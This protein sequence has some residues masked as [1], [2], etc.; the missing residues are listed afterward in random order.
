VKLEGPTVRRFCNLALWCLGGVAVLV[1]AAQRHAHL[2][3]RPLHADEAVQAWTTW[4]VLCGT[5]YRY[6]PADRHGPFIYLAAAAVERLTGG[7]AH[8]WDEEAARRFTWLAGIATLL[9]LAFGARAGLGAGAATVAAALLAFEPISTLYHTYYVQ[10]AWLALFTWA[11]VLLACSAAANTSR[12]RDGAV[13]ARAGLAMPL[14][15]GLLAGLAVANKEVAPLYLGVGLFAV[16]WVHRPPRPSARAWAWAVGGGLAVYVLFYAS[17]GQN[18]AGVLDGLRGY[19]LQMQRRADPAH[20][21]PPDYFLAMLLPHRAGGIA[22]GHT[23]LLIL[24]LLGAVLAGRREARTARV[25]ALLTITLLVL[26]SAVPYKTPWLLLT[27]MLGLVM[28][29]GTALAWMA[30]WPRAG[31]L[32]A[33]AAFGLTAGELHRRSYLALDRY[34][35][36]S[37]T[38]YFYQQTPR[39]FLRLVTQLEQLD[40]ATPSVAPALRVAVVSAESAW[41]L[42]W[43]LRDWVQVGYFVTPPADPASWD[44]VVWDPQVGP[45]PEAWWAGRQVLLHGIRPGLLLHVAVSSSIWDRAFPIEPSPP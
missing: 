43:Y 41:P 1:G 15:L 31:W 44:L 42:P 11:F 35:G 10:E 19:G 30:S 23:G 12:G 27:P 21:Q 4:Q 32:V 8:T 14:T 26:H 9:L 45:M 28:L 3:D 7:G 5:P 36:D 6:D 22:W 16:G 39:G 25:V 24:A 20:S 17:F 2:A 34:P 38:P 37:R 29:A 13:S 33:L 40:R 18:P